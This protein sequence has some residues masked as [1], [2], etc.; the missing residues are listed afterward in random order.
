MKTQIFKSYED[1]LERADKKIN[2][3]S[4]DFAAKHPDFEESNESKSGCWNCYDCKNCESCN[5][6]VSCEL[7]NWCENREN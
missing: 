3:V 4:E 1:F 7:C 2:G 5:W 6:C